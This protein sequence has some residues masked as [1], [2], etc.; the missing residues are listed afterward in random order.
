MVDVVVVG[1]LSIFVLVEIVGRLLGGD[2][3]GRAPASV[4]LLGLSNTRAAVALVVVLV[5]YEV[6]PVVLRGATLGKAMLGLAV[7]ELP[8]WRRPDALSAT[9]RALV[10]YGPLALPTI[11]LALSLIV[12]APAL[13]WPTRR[14]L[15]DLAA[16]TVVVAGRGRN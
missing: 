10:L 2:P 11:G 6:V 8:E 16:G 5:L 7:V 12:V 14:G 13:I 3:L 1:W 4:H 9:I 15:H